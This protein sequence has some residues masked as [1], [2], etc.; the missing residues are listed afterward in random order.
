ML[1]FFQPKGRCDPNRTENV[2]C[3][4][5]CQGKCSTRPSKCCNRKLAREQKDQED[6]KFASRLRRR[7]SCFIPNIRKGSSDDK[8]CNGGGQDSLQSVQQNQQGGQVNQINQESDQQNAQGSLNAQSTQTTQAIPNVE[9]S[10]D[11]ERPDVAVG[12]V[13]HHTLYS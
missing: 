10:G 13:L 12:E 1:N 11:D 5:N 6:R 4:W 7:I 3:V 2:G 8:D 9:N